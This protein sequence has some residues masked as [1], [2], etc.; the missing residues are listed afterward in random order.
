MKMIQ[1]QFTYECGRCGNVVRRTYRTTDDG[2]IEVPLV[3]CGRCVGHR[4]LS[5]MS[6]TMSEEKVIET[7]DKKP[8]VRGLPRQ[9]EVSG[10]GNRT[11]PAYGSKEGRKSAN[12]ASKSTEGIGS[13]GVTGVPGVSA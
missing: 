4:H 1:V 8:E 3:W 9:S 6:S 12:D 7:P 5:V 13:D 11:A 10:S 2:L